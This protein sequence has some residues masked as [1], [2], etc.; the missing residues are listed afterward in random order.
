MCVGQNSSRLGQISIN[1]NKEQTAFLAD[2]SGKRAEAGTI[3]KVVLGKSVV[4]NV[5]VSC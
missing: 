3:A 2:M 5:A 4:S 1:A